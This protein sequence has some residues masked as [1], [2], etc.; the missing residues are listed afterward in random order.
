VKLCGS[1]YVGA[2]ESTLARVCAARLSADS[3]RTSLCPPIPVDEDTEAK[4]KPVRNWPRTR[5]HLR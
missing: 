1:A 2:C 3:F 5:F 4:A